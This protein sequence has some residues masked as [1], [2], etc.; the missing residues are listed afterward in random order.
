MAKNEK[1]INGTKYKVITAVTGHKINS[2]GNEVAIK[3]TILWQNL[4]G[5]QGEA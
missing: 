1:I 5:S 2:A 4:K 3:K